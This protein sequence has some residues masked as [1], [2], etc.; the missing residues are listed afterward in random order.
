MG[1]AT[2]RD[3]YFVITNIPLGIYEINA[4]MMG[5]GVQKKDIDLSVLYSPDLIKTKFISSKKHYNFKKHIL[6]S[7]KIKFQTKNGIGYLPISPFLLFKLI[8]KKKPSQID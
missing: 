6:K 4:S 3:G 2:N 5:Y 7:F 1:A 8:S